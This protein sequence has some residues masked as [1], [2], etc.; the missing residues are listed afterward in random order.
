MRL[1][2]AI[3]FETRTKGELGEIRDALRERTQRGSFTRT[4]NFHLTLVFLGEV[5]GDRVPDITRAMDNIKS[6]PFELTMGGLGRFSRAGG[7]V[8]WIGVQK[9]PELGQ[10]Q[11]ALSRAL[12]AQGFEIE[13][14]VY[15]PHLTLAR[16]VV[17]AGEVDR[18]T[19]EIVYRVAAM[20][21]M[22]SERIDGALV[23]TPIHETSFD[24]AE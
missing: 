11:S 2:V 17:T 3:D 9:S 7:D 24:I 19:R 8:W 16:Q 10:L 4:E 21:L 14:R 15:T 1:F 13:Q 5:P 18:A 23:Y 22:C 12:A 6:I 20:Q